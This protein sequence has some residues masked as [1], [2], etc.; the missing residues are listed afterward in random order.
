MD[1]WQEYFREINLDQKERKIINRFL[2]M[3][4]KQNFLVASEILKK[5]GKDVEAFELICW[6]LEE[7]PDYVPAKVAYSRE[8]FEKGFIVDV[9]KTLIV[10]Q[11][12]LGENTL[13]LNL[14]FKSS[15]LLS[16]EKEFEQLKNSLKLN[17]CFDQQSAIAFD[18]Y[19][20]KG[21]SESR[22]YLLG[23]FKS[24]QIDVN[25][26]SMFLN[27]SPAHPD[28]NLV[29]I[30]DPETYLAEIKKEQDHI[31]RDK[32]LNQFKMKHLSEV[33]LKDSV[34]EDFD[35]ESEE[36]ANAQLAIGFYERLM[37]ELS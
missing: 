7:F 4:Q 24:R 18:L 3:V 37:T 1:R 21:M 10:A 29:D 5:Y 9:W 2:K 25:L 11:E 6:G 15:I 19:E 8:M 30:K 28:L 36:F 31:W 17:R 20:Q 27:Q 34:E 22:E 16:Y 35:E 12:L 33:F 14:L 13:A 23:V 32:N 26:K